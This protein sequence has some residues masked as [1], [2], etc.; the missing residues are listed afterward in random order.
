MAAYSKQRL[1]IAAMKQALVV[2]QG[3]KRKTSRSPRV[4]RVEDRITATERTAIVAAYAEARH[5]AD[6]I[7]TFKTTRHVIHRLVDEAG[8]ARRISVPSPSDEDRAVRLYQ[9]GNS[10]A[11]VGRAI[12]FDACTV[13]RIL[14]ARDIPRRDSHG[15][16][17]PT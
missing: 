7:S 1:Q 15:H 2:P 10:L 17:R 6:I 12:G 5:L 8:V 13:R 16:V 9:S 4:H 3:D 14:I 11:T